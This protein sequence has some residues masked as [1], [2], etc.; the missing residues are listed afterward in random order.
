M[1][2][3]K[4][5]RYRFTVFKQ[6]K[7]VAGGLE[8]NA[9]EEQVESRRRFGRP[10]QIYVILYNFLRS[11]THHSSRAGRAI[12]PNRRHR[13]YPF[14]AYIP[15]TS[16]LFY[17]IMIRDFLSK[18]IS[19]PFFL[20]CHCAIVLDTG[21]DKFPLLVYF[22]PMMNLIYKQMVPSKKSR[23]YRCKPKGLTI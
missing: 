14:L 7:A 23:L 4:I 17:Y 11:M 6:P 22:D 20:V 21:W 18:K 13:I 5:K 15:L 9:G 3:K 10:A 19:T 2:L 8:E 16:K 12:F 1:T